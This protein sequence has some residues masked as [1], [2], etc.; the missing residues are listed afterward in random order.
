MQP[1]FQVA[2]ALHLS[3]QRNDAQAKGRLGSKKSRHRAGVVVIEHL[4]RLVS[5]SDDY[6]QRI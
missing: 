6:R 2:V 5:H 3:S 4:L 1:D